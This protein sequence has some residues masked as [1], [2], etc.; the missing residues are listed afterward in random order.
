MDMES[1]DPAQVPEDAQLI[2]VREQNEWDAGHAPT[3]QHVPASSIVEHLGELPEEGDLYIVCRSGGRSAQAT[4]WLNQNGYD[5][6][7]VAG[8]MDEWFEQG[9]P[10]V[11]DGDQEPRV[12]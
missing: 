3:A 11:A 7:N 5:A 8:G 6:I 9:L 1:V 12:L 2:D 4:M 10:M